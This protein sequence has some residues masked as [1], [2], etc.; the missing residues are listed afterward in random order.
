MM[1]PDEIQMRQFKLQ[2]QELE[3]KRAQLA[4]EFAK[5]G[6]AGAL[7]AAVVG[8]TLVLALA[9]LDAISA[10]FSFGV[11][12]VAVAMA[13]LAVSCIAFGAFSLWQP[14][15]ILARFGKMSF[16]FKSNDEEA[17]PPKQD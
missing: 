1:T 17:V 6:F 12:G 9:I 14:V 13:C 4:V 7:V 10:E 2:E 16:G 11:E 5:Y 8:M 15:K 3:L